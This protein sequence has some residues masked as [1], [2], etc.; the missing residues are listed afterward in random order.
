MAKKENP[1]F[2]HD[3][4]NVDV[5]GMVVLELKSIGLGYSGHY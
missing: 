5:A 3:D 4:C 1:H 2:L